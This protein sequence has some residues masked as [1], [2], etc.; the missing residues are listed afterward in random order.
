MTSPAGPLGA[1]GIDAR[2][3][4][5]YRALL[6][7][8]Q[9]SVS[10]LVERLGLDH[11]EV[12]EL[13]APLE[14]RGLVSRRGDAL[15]ALSPYLSLG[16]LVDD[17][18]RRLREREHALEHLRHSLAD[19]AAEEK[20]VDL[21]ESSIQ[22][23]VVHSGAEIGA[24]VDALVRGTT[25]EMLFLHSVEWLDN[26]GWSKIDSLITGQ[27]AGGRSVRSIYPTE[28]LH[29]PETLD[30]VRGWAEHGEEVRLAASPPSRM[31]VFGTAAALVPVHWGRT[32]AQR[33]VV[34][35]PGIVDALRCLFDTIWRHA[36]PLPDL[37]AAAGSPTAASD[38]VLRLL[39]AGA[40]D[41]T[42]ARQLGLSLRTVR[43]RVADLLDELDATTRFQAGVEAARRGLV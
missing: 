11:E 29:R 17:E 10:E 14:E 34:R 3:D 36:V 38:Q 18:A 12:A 4:R 7:V 24:V 43:R 16:R 23:V 41:E 35:T 40:K 6:R 1:F 28:V 21:S 15:V 5:V 22:P 19:Y 26:P 8:G 37:G 25:G 27:V 32:P 42:M 9:S 30:L 39:A 2:A 33:I 31:A 13:L 20:G